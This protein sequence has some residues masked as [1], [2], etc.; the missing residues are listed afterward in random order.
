[1]L[2]GVTALVACG[3]ASDEP[4]SAA[5]PNP[6]PTAIASP[7][8]A[9]LGFVSD[10]GLRQYQLLLMQR[11]ADAAMVG[12]MRQAGFFYAVRPAEQ[13]FRSGAF[14]GDGSLDW[15]TVNGFGVTSSF[16][17]ALAADA[18]NTTADAETT[19]R[20][21]VDSLTPEQA[22]QYDLAL[23]GDVVPDPET[24][25]YEPAGC[26]GA[27]YTEM[28]RLLAILDEFEPE[29]ALL[30][31]RLEADPRV[32]E[33]DRTWS[34][35]MQAAGYNY[36]NQNALV[37][38]VY[39]RLLDI[40]LVENAGVTQVVSGDALEGLAEFERQAAVASHACEASFSQDLAQLRS[41]YESE[42]LDDNRFRIAELQ[43]ES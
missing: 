25:A 42:F 5:A 10:P 14:V 17:S 12:C 6:T 15:T 30:N 38:D 13:V 37:D 34:S 20:G 22:A 23:V 2:F 26:W 9:S 39:A 16:S 1:M 21:Y 24:A 28:L 11:E 7:L 19:N 4:P 27:S 8:E 33:F 41:D 31:S 36:E 29:L 32:I 18:A 40:E 3:G 35:C 43:P